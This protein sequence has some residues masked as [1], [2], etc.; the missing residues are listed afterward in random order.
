MRQKQTR[1]KR[2]STPAR[3]PSRPA[4]LTK[5]LE[6]VG[7]FSRVA[8]RG[9]WTLGHVLQ[10]AKGKHQSQLVIDAIVAEV[11][12]IEQDAEDAA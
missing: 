9:G 10:V 11:R 6:H 12:R 2:K 4:E 8:K 3:K 7:L 5:A 1:Q